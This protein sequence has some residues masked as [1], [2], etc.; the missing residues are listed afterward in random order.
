[1]DG[2]IGLISSGADMELNT[3]DVVAGLPINITALATTEGNA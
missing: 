2:D 1:M 3:V